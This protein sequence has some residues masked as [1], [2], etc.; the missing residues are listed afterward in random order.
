MEADIK[1]MSGRF[2]EMIKEKSELE[3]NLIQEQMNT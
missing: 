3:Q 1:A 2:E